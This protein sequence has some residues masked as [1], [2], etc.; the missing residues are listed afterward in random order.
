LSKYVKVTESH[1]GLSRHSNYYFVIDGNKLVH[2]SKYATL[3][4]HKDSDRVEYTVD[5]SNL[6]GKTIIEIMSSNS[7]IYC[8]VEEYPAEDLGLD[9]SSRRRARR[10]LSYLNNFDLSHLG[11]EERE[12]LSRD[13][14]QYYMPMIEQL[15]DFL[16]LVKNKKLNLPNKV[17]DVYIDLPSLIDC[18]IKSYVNYPL[19]FLIPYS[20][21]ARKKSLEGLTREIHQIWVATRIIMEINNRNILRSLT[22]SSSDF[23]SLDFKQ[24]SSYP[25]ATFNCG[26]DTC[27]IWYEFDL[28]INT[29]CDGMLIDAVVVKTSSIELP[30]NTYTSESTRQIESDLLKKYVKEIFEN[31]VPWAQALE[32]L[33]AQARKYVK[34]IFENAE[35]DISR[36]PN[37]I[38]KIY[39][40]VIKVKGLKGY[41]DLIKVKRENRVPLRPDIVILRGINSCKDFK[42]VDEIKVKVLIE[43]K[44]LDP[45][46][47][48]QDVDNQIIPY[49]QIFQPDIAILASLKK[50]PEDIKIKL[51][52]NGIKVIEYVYPGGRGEKELLDIIKAL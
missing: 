38:K 1:R 33:W 44:N 48:R 2:I 26:H 51:N 11:P 13:W 43:C 16:D 14:K 20:L 15:R 46:Y 12:F 47:W 39:E 40:R 50:V 31:D 21:N 25:I 19:S 42:N 30:D 41:E 18:Q 27:S 3:P 23:L 8:D 6:S 4:P 9:Y 24:G 34:E 32:Y 28:N 5:L 22:L 7:G 45:E 49:K 17:S 10:P 37:G 35:V 36:L 29:M 52:K